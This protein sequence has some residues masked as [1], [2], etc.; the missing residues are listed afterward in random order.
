MAHTDFSIYTSYIVYVNPGIPPSNFPKYD[1]VIIAY[2]KFHK[3]A[4]FKSN[5]ELGNPNSGG[6][7]MTMTVAEKLEASDVGIENLR[8]KS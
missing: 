8:R 3:T 1:F 4:H 7:V 5:P 6:S 2:S